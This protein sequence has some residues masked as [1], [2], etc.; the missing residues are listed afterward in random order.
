MRIKRVAVADR[1]MHVPAEIGGGAIK[2]IVDHFRNLGPPL[3]CTIEHVV[4][5]AVLG[6]QSCER[7]S[8][9]PFD[10]VTESAELCSGVHRVHRVAPGSSQSNRSPPP[11]R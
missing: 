5:N 4:I 1:R 10:G 7:F 8:V 9:M 6:E 3:E 2:N 11:P